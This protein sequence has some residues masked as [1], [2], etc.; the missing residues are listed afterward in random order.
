M[1]EKIERTISFKF[2]NTRIKSLKIKCMT[3]KPFVLEGVT[4]KDVN[5]I[6]SN[7]KKHEN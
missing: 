2:K 4:L 1:P 7:P 6:E 5:L 3:S